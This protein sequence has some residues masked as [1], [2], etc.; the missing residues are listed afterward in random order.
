MET[1]NV[2]HCLVFPLFPDLAPIHLQQYDFLTAILR[3]CLTTV[4]MVQHDQ[5]LLSLHI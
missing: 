1:K 3:T 2:T 5:A 4:D